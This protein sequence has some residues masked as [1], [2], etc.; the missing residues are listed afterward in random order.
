MSRVLTHT[1]IPSA[2]EAAASRFEASLV[3]GVSSRAAQGYT[4]N[5]CL[6][7]RGVGE[8]EEEVFTDV[9]GEWKQWQWQQQ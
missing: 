8:W 9:N 1:F 4:E 5:P 2:W 3:Y 6:E 7:G